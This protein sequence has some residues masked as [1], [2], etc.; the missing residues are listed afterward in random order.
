MQ[1]LSLR[2]TLGRRASSWKSDLVELIVLIVALMSMHCLVPKKEG[3]GEM[4]R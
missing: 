3:R 1:T 2:G 4:E